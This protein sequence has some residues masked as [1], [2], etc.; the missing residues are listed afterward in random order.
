MTVSG[1]VLGLLLVV[2]AFIDVFRRPQRRLGNYDD[3]RTS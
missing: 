3:A 1:A 2:L